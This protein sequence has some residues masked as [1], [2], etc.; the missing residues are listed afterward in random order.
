MILSNEEVLELCVNPASNDA[1]I[2]SRA[3]QLSFKKHITG[4]SY[5]SIIKELSGYTSKE[6]KQLER[7]LAKSPTIELTKIVIDELS[8]WKNAQG[9]NK[10]FYFK[11]KELEKDFVKTLDQV[12]KGDSANYFIKGFFSEALFTEFAGF[13]FVDK[14][15]IKKRG[16]IEVIIRE[17]KEFK[18][19]KDELDPYWIFISIEDVIDFKC[20]NDTVEYLIWKV[21]ER[22][23]KGNFTPNS[24]PNN[25][26]EV[27]RCV[28]ESLDRLVD[29]K[30]NRGKV[31]NAVTIISEISNELKY[32]PARQISTVKKT[33]TIDE[34]RTNHIDQLLPQLDRYIE[35][36]IQLI[37]REVL[38]N[39]PKLSVIGVKCSYCGGTGVI[40]D[41]D[42]KKVCPRCLGSGKLNPFN[43]DGVIFLPQALEEG[44][45]AYPGSPA[46]YVT[47]DIDSLEF[48]KERLADLR[49]AIIFAGTGNK[50][51]VTERLQT[52]TETITNAKTLED[53]IG[54]ILD[55]IEAV[56][57]FLVDTTAKKH[58]KFAGSYENCHIRYGRKLN[59]RDEETIL[60]EIKL[61][62]ES[63][64]PESHI[65]NLQ[66]E[67]IASRYRNSPEDLKR[68]LLLADIEP[69]C[70]YSIAEIRNFAEQID[71]SILSLKVNFNER[72]DTFEAE[73]G[74]ITDYKPD[75]DYDKRVNE[76]RQ[77]LLNYEETNTNNTDT[78]GPTET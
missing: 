20:S 64:M 18:R 48:A 47:P 19:S 8:R 57:T 15:L 6:K 65:E 44:K 30:K 11:N 72:V 35:K 41:N 29:V 22:D 45:S 71:S 13:I 56:E 78:T 43:E 12:W 59:L 66:K 21:G 26:I 42:E 38:H 3:L 54:D 49:D 50:N 14:P 1:I 63:G 70:S 23:R 24:N 68:N 31:K 33:I 46:A 53:R 58:N 34:S 60:K 39:F 2:A 9:T 28:D 75:F 73:H 61:S 4:E 25:P 77:I 74:A 37:K 5:V 76:I 69:L 17:N 67:L 52:A 40:D 51:L 36:D 10:R 32:V 27:Y 62:K 16:D 55:N 7:L